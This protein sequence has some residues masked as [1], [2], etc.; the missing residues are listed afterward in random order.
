M[1]EYG[2][3]LKDLLAIGLLKNTSIRPIALLEPKCATS[4]NIILRLRR[5][6]LESSPK[7]FRFHPPFANAKVQRVV[8]NA[9]PNQMR[10]CEIFT[11]IFRRLALKSDR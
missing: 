6:V 11:S 8:L 7:A 4:R 1:A 9:L 2:L 10:L 3:L 5:L